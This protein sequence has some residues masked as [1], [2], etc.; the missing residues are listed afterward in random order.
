MATKKQYVIRR[1][2]L[3]T[4]EF[5]N[6][7]GKWDALF[8]AK[9][10]N[11]QPAAMAFAVAHDAPDCGLFQAWPKKRLT[12][13]MSQYLTAVARGRSPAVNFRSSADYGGSNGTRYSLYRAGLIDQDNNITEA[14]RRAIEL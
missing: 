13:P 1:N 4:E 5:M 8:F 9:R 12:D 3:K 7:Q 6:D 11:T 2:S 14:G 10:F